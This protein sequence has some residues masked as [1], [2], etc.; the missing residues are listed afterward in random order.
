MLLKIVRFRKWAARRC[1]PAQ[2]SRYRG[3]A[4]AL[5]LQAAPKLAEAILGPARFK[6]RQSAVDALVFVFI[7]VVEYLRGK[8]RIDTATNEVLEQ[9]VAAERFG[10]E[11]PADKELGKGTVVDVLTPL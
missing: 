7:G 11:L 6:P 8:F 2:R 5:A 3:G 4:K 9:P 10:V 1:P